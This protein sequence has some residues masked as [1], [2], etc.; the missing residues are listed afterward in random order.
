MIA[1]SNPVNAASH[2]EMKPDRELL[3]EARGGV[4]ESFELL[5]RRHHRVVLAFLWRRVQEPE[6]AA[7]LMAETFAALLVRVRDWEQSLPPVPIAWLLATARH[8]LIDGYR[9]GQVEDSARRR[10]AMRPVTLEDPD[11]GRIA[12]ISAETDLLSELATQ[13]SADQLE[14]LRLR[15]LEDR[16]YG[17]IAARVHCSESVVRKRVSRA[18]RVLRRSMEGS[19]DG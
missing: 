12:E 18:L 3:E 6:L 15:V 2:P 1:L 11:L 17:E 7:D 13:L 16:D 14:A 9:R 10:L 5:Y 8:L 4:G 19:N